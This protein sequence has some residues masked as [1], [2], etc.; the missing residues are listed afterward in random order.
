MLRRRWPAGLGRRLTPLAVPMTIALC[1][2]VVGAARQAAKRPGRL[3]L[4]KG[5]R[6]LPGIPGCFA[7]ASERQVVTLREG[8]ANGLLLEAVNLDTRAARPLMRIEGA[9]A[10]DVLPWRFS[11]SP[12]G[13]Q[14]LWTARDRSDARWVATTLD[15]AVVVEWPSLSPGHG[16]VV[17][18][19]LGVVWK[20]D[21]SGWVE[22]YDG[23]VAIYSLDP[24]RAPTQFS[25]PGA[26]ET[27]LPLGFT[28]ANELLVD[29]GAS[30][31]VRGDRRES[32]LLVRPFDAKP[33]WRRFSAPMPVE[34]EVTGIALSPA[35][36]RLAW[37][38]S[39]LIN[40]FRWTGQRE[41]HPFSVEVR[42]PWWSFWLS[43]VDGTGMTEIGGLLS[44]D[45]GP[46]RPF[47]V[48]DLAWAP[49]GHQLS[50]S[51]GGRNWAVPVHAISRRDGIQ[52][53][54][55]AGTS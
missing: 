13:R 31:P 4:L 29:M 43:D 39:K 26:G 8:S 17:S 37:V 40:W 1:L 15:G 35:G 52:P 53:N 27:G 36:D 49:G 14:L 10:R 32:F 12:N 34:E 30:G 11:L 18:S 24:N 16:G 54:A 22:V 9:F 25:M 21:G 7:W 28:R 20:R 51:Y 23:R 5:A 33:S 38:M 6:L 45:T 41:G 42:I 2:P 47:A 19:P 3:P 50:F 55:K 46:E 48:D 44:T